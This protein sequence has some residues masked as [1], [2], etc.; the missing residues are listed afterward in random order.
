MV[1]SVKQRSYMW[2]YAAIVFEQASTIRYP[3]TVCV[4]AY[5]R[6]RLP[7]LTVEYGATRWCGV[8]AYGICSAGCYDSGQLP[9]IAM[10]E[11]TGSPDHWV[12]LRCA[13]LEDFDVSCLL[14][15]PLGVKTVEGLDWSWS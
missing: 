7:P 12:A 2:I 9:C 1:L 5:V 3:C 8:T 11:V 13:T 4:S 10:H 15:L 14:Q 6:R